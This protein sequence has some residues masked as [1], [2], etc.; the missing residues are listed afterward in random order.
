MKKIILCVFVSVV[1]MSCKKPAESIS[2]IDSIKDSAETALKYKLN[3][4]KSYE[5]ISL[6]DNFETLD[7]IQYYEGKKA[8]LDTIEKFKEYSQNKYKSIEDKYAFDSSSVLLSL[9]CRATNDKNALMRTE[10]LIVCDKDS[11]FKE[12]QDLN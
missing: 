7:L 12:I 6:D 10:Y 4:P 5:F 3:D 8:K 11:I 2:K 1:L 9:K